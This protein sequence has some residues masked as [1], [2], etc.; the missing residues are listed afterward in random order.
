[1]FI[2]IS[3]RTSDVRRRSGIRKQNW[4]QRVNKKK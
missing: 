3:Y 4:K 2:K 1:M